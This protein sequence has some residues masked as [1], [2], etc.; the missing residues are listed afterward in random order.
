L[1]YATEFGRV[2]ADLDRCHR[3][4][5]SIGHGDRSDWWNRPIRPGSAL[6]TEAGGRV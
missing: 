6:R 4:Q 3:S 5:R 2:R 1:I